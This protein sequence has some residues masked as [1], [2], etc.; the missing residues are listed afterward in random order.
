MELQLSLAVEIRPLRGGDLDD[1][2]WDSEQAIDAEYIRKVLA[3]EGDEHAVFLLA[4]VNGRPV[5]RLGIDYRRKAEEGIVHLWAFG[6]LPALQRLGIGT[7]LM[8]EAER[9]IASA[10]RAATRIEIGV[11]EGNDEAAKLY[12]RLGYRDA[13]V[14]RGRSGE[15]IRLLRRPIFTTSPS[16]T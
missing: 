6:V 1:L 4:L 13:G 16:R 3:G 11:E 12:R 8:R 2:D 15:T 10:P 9:L 5:G 14:E 7:A